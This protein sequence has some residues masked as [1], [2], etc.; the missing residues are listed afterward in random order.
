MPEQVG[1]GLYNLVIPPCIGNI[2][3][4][5]YE[6]CRLPGDIQACSLVASR[7]LS[8]TTLQ[9]S[10]CSGVPDQ[11]GLVLYVIFIPLCIGNISFV[12]HELCRLPGDYETR[13]VAASRWPSFATL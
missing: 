4:V 13:S 6:L 2:S 3:F 10:L 5:S 12:S 9:G 8:F 1:L 7:R 11:V